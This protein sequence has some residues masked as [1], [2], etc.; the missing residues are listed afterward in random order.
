MVTIL[1]AQRLYKSLASAHGK[2]PKLESLVR[3]FL[4]RDFLYSGFFDLALSKYHTCFPVWESQ[5]GSSVRERSL[6]LQEY[7]L[8]HI[9]N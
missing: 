3:E 7:V 9:L 4:S 5:L 8:S 2:E 6:A 1:I